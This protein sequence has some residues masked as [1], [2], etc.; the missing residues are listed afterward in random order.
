MIKHKMKKIINTILFVLPL[1]I[2]SQ[3]KVS[4]NNSNN[5]VNIPLIS[6][7][8]DRFY[9]SALTFFKKLSTNGAG[10][11][12]NI[13]FELKNRSE[14]NINLDIVM[15]AYHQTDGV[16]KSQRRFIQYPTWREKD[17]EKLEINTLFQDSIPPMEPTKGEGKENENEFERVVALCTDGKIKGNSLVIKGINTGNVP[18]TKYEKMTMMNQPLKTMI[19]AKLNVAF[20]EDNK[21]FNNFGLIL[22]DSQT[23]KVVYTQLYHFTKPFKIQ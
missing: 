16:D 23:K 13:S 19:F 17:P 3:D 2:Y 14:K 4:G 8:D 20:N 5:K 22:I 15:V 12:L 21:F 7:L 9:V 18:V 10:Q 1:V 6:Q 11:E